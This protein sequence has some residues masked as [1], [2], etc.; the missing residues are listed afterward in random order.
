M[1]IAIIKLSA[2][3]DI[4]HAMV[5]PQLIKKR[6]PHAKIDWVVEAGFESILTQNKD[7]HQI[8]CV[9]LKRAKK[10]KSIKML[11]AELKKVRK[12]ETYDVV[13]DLQG[14]LKSALIAKLIP[15]KQTWGFDKHSIRESL[16]SLFY[17]HT[18]N[19]SYGENIIKRNAVLASQALK[20]NFSMQDIMHKTPLLSAHFFRPS[21]GV[22]LVLGASFI[23]KCYPVEKYAQLV[24]LMKISPW[25]IWGNEQEHALAQRLKTLAPSVKISERMSLNALIDFI[26]TANLVIG[27]DTGPVHMAWALNVPSIVLFGATPAK[28]NAWHSPINLTLKS[29]ACV[30]IYHIDKYDDSIKDI[31][32]KMIAKQ[33]Q[34]LLLNLQSNLE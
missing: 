3:G 30:D 19:I 7:I 2:L 31:S 5:V 15:S 10:N 20:F 24:H 22:V 26:A 23:S 18:A 34:S 4:I 16:A 33:A 29:N 21:S 11:F 12:M 8:Y 1:K 13:I 25:V 32:V 6:Y 27:G 17:N 28:R 14:L 9:Q